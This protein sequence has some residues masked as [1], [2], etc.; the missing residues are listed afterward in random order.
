MPIWDVSSITLQLDVAG[1]F[2]CKPFRSGSVVVNFWQIEPISH[3]SARKS[4]R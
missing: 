4:W 3:V 1:G 2:I